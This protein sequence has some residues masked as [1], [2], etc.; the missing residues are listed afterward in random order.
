MVKIERIENEITKNAILSLEKAK[1]NGTTYNT[2]EV[3][4]ALYAIFYGKCYICENKQGSSY[5]IEHLRP[6]KKISL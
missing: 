3:N 1:Q 6:H 5:Q 4:N 2:P